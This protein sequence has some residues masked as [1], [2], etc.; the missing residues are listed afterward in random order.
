MRGTLTAAATKGATGAMVIKFKEV[1][2]K[3]IRKHDDRIVDLRT[4]EHWTRVK[5]HGLEL[6]RYGKSP[7]G[8]RILRQEIEAE[9]PGVIIPL[10]V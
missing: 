8:L 6:N 4:N 7:E 5:I 2:L 1:I 3:A 9:N 10:A